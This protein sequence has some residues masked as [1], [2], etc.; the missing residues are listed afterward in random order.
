VSAPDEPTPDASTGGWARADLPSYGPDWDR[1]IEFGI[2]VTLLLENLE[3]SPAERLARLQQ[4]V[5]FHALLRG[6]GHGDQ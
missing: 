6:A 3:R 1:A 2:D 5:D 4:M